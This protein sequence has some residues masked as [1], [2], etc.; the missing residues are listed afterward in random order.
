[1]P[2]GLPVT[3]SIVGARYRSTDG[4]HAGAKR[5]KTLTAR[6]VVLVS[7]TGTNLQALLD[8]CADPRYGAQIVAV[9]ADREGIGGLDRAAR[10]GVP[11]F[12]VRLRDY[13]DRA[14]WDHALTEAVASHAPDLVILAG[15]MKI[16]GAEFVERF[17]N[18]IVNTHPALL[19]AF[20]GAH[21]VRETL[22]YGVK[23]TGVT[24]HLVDSEVDHGP[25][26]AQAPVPVLDGDDEKRLHERIKTVERELLVQTVGRMIR[27]GYRVEGRKV[28]L[29]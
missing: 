17:P 28:H 26:L 10:A 2:R 7:G 21:A 19:P 3:T 11:M 8:A 16:V 23:V 9:G 20:R 18:R 24:V 14:A 12:A 25:V 6:L 29:P 4:T 22:A 13:S 27:G 15:F 5:G 1:V